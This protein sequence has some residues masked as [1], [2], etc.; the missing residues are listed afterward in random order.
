[1]CGNGVWK[2]HGTS[3]EYHLGSI[4]IKESAMEKHL[5][6]CLAKELKG[7]MEYI[8]SRIKSSQTVT[9]YCKYTVLVSK[10]HQTYIL[11]CVE[12][13]NIGWEIVQDMEAFHCYSAK[14]IQGL[15]RQ[16]ATS[17]GLISVGWRSLEGVDGIAKL[18]FMWHVLLLPMSCMYNVVM[19]KRMYSIL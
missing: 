17:Q 5:G 18:Q 19:V 6:V 1:M 7:K 11:L 14:L 9:I 4:K 2:R 3:H 10:Y 8:K 12:A 13:M 16:A 15:L